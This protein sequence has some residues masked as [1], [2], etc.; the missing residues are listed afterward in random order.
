MIN[1]NMNL[2]ANTNNTMLNPQLILLRNLLRVHTLMVHQLVIHGVFI[3]IKQ[4][5]MDFVR[6]VDTYERG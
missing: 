2:L 3:A 1:E 5:K 4:S 6:T